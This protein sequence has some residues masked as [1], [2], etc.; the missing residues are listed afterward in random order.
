MAGQ[1]SD[2]HQGKALFET[3]LVFGI[4]ACTCFSALPG[5]LAVFQ[6]LKEGM[7]PISQRN[8]DQPVTE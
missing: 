5:F 2:Y 6:S 4:P 7:S 3:G 1:T 8:P